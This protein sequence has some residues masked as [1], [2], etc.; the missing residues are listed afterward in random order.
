LP[1]RTTGDG[2]PICQAPGCEK[3][4]VYNKR[5]EK[6]MGAWCSMHRQRLQKYGS[7]DIPEDRKKKVTQIQNTP[8]ARLPEVQ[9]AVEAR[10]TELQ[11]YVQEH[12]L[13]AL[14]THLE[15]THIRP[16]LGDELDRIRTE[17]PERQSKPGKERRVEVQIT[18][19]E[20]DLERKV[21]ELKA[22]VDQRGEEYGNLQAIV[23]GQRER[24]QRAN[25]RIEEL[26]ASGNACDHGDLR[27]EI[28]SL[29]AERAAHDATIQT[30]R[31]QVAAY[32]GADSIDPALHQAAIQAVTDA[33]HANISLTN[34][35]SALK[36]INEHMAIALSLA[37]GT[38][39]S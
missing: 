25:A 3:K 27:L 8:I 28:D 34:K 9:A 37:L 33:T 29:K 23:S 24:L 6:Y 30:L 15:E 2:T 5:S 17:V 7:L 11:D 38:M 36:K 18:A 20:L 10:M 4:K 35:N 22:E 32:A 19:R 16:L 39:E 14:S 31:A 13:S 1:T 26:E 12:G 21:E